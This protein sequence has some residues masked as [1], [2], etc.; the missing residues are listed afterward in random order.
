MI[1]FILLLLLVPVKGP[2]EGGPVTLKGAGH[3]DQ[4]CR[5]ILTKMLP[6]TFIYEARGRWAVLTL[7]SNCKI[8]DV[9]SFGPLVKPLF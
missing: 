5:P 3:F 7:H 8:K 9:S 2:T 4:P 1:G 6:V